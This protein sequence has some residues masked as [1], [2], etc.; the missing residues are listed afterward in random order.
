MRKNNGF[1]TT[2]IIRHKMGDIE[3]FPVTKE[4][5]D[6]IEKGSNS[7]LFLEIALCLIS[8]FASFLCSLLVIDFVSYPNAFNF[9]LFI[10]IISGLASIIMFVLWWR[11]RKNKHELIN[12]IRSQAIEE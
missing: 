12:K 7:D 2:R 11:T 4:Q 3:V 10:C 5:L 8:V 6:E 9:Y 1:G